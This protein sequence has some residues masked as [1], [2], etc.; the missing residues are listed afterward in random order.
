MP[1]RIGRVHG[2]GGGIYSS[3]GL[4][5]KVLR[6]LTTTTGFTERKRDYE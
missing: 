2:S 5:P 4:M 3:R 6:K 1:G